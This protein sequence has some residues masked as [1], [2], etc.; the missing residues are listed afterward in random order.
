MRLTVPLCKSFLILLI[1]LNTSLYAGTK[2][3]LAGT[4]TDISTGEPLL[5]VNIYF[6]DEAIGG[7][8]DLN[9]QYIVLNITPG[10]YTTVIEHIG[11]NT[12]RVEN[13][14]IS[15]DL[16]T[17]LDVALQEQT[18]ESEVIIVNAV[19][20]LIQQDLTSKLS[21]IGGETINAMPVSNFNDVVASQAGITKDSEGNLHF[22][23][24]RTNEVTFLI[25]GQQVE[26][27]IDNSFSG[28]IDNY[29]ISELQVLSGTFNA[30]YGQAMSGVINIITKD[31]SPNFNSKI[32]YSSPMLNSSRYRK[33]DALIKDANPFYDKQN[34]LRL[35]YNE[36]DGLDTFD[37]L[38][39]NEGTFKGFIS[40]PLPFNVGSYFFSGEYLNENSWKPFGYD[41]T[42]SGFGKLTFPFAKNKLSL[43]FQ[44]SDQ[45]AQP[46][47]H[48]YK[49]L[50]QNSGH[51]ENQSSRIALQLNHY[52]STSSYFVLNATFLDH[53]ALYRVG[54][55]NYADYIFP[56]PDENI[57]FIVNGN[58]KA[59]SDFK[60]TTLNLKGDWI[61][62]YGKHHELKS[63]FEFNQ[64]DFDVFDY[65]NEGNGADEF[66]LN[67]NKKS[68]QSASFYIQDK[69][70]YTSIVVNAG[71]R[72]DYIDVK[73]KAFK[74]IERPDLGIDDSSPELKISPRLGLAY[75]IGENTSLHFSYG[76]FLQ[77]PNFQNIYQ[78]LQF[79]NPDVLQVARF[80]IVANP[81]VKSQK[82]VSYEIG[83]SQ[84]LSETFA[85]H[86]TAYSKDITDLLGTINVSSSADYNYSI[87]TNNDFARIQ[88]VDISFEKRMSGYW[89]AKIDYTYS[90][91]R[92]N[93]ATPLEEAYNIFEGREL[94]VKEF[95]LDFDRR[96]DFAINLTSRLPKSFGPDI[97]GFQPF[98]NFS[99]SILAQFSS[100]LPYTPSSEDFTKRF[101]KNSARMPW[102]KTIDIRL[103]KFIPAS[104]FTFSLFAEVTN[105][106]DWLN[107]LVV[108]PRTGVVWDDGVSTLFGSG[109]DFKH[110]PNHVGAPRIIKLGATIALK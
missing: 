7:S 33:A 105:L 48:K 100:G 90:V 21:V 99:T 97:F 85:L 62:Q 39:P 9:G 38:F 86:L 81:N 64:Y 77:F 87:F 28:L 5:G 3:K 67:E 107:P 103:E 20:P 57:E 26:N 42:R 29:A 1:I 63:G 10:N 80:A 52:L 61:L 25:D 49:Y 8:T 18:L 22:R 46:Y 94:S 53:Q 60:S 55:L 96:H 98:S 59:Y 75:P 31:G 24:G 69:M 11:F 65:S 93:E 104:L 45:E 78:N 4:I 37:P 89:A 76:H 108:Q 16:T 83:V 15:A 84:K 102:T 79:L 101:E 30:E 51:W 35:K 71:L 19:R 82:T 23:G 41:F 2:G 72:A 43:T 91:A 44:L 95:Y 54:S 13:V 34:E 56:D 40:G 47:N 50:P 88:G 106:F 70:E 73:A 27:P 66:F 6:E 32:E 68:P 36:T 92:G 14:K 17:I 110:N 74:N 58:D 12:Q 109:K